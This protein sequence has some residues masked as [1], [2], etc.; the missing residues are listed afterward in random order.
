[1]REMLQKALAQLPLAQREA[2]ILREYNGYTYQEI[3]EITNSTMINAKTRAWRA[4][5]RLRK[6]IGAWL[7]LKNMEL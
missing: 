7:E 1:L 4:R 6:M 5:E 3:G 2:F